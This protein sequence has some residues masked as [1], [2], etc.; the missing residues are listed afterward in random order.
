MPDARLDPAAG[1]FPNIG[2]P[3]L[4]A[5]RLAGITR[6]EDCAAWTRRDLAA[7]HGVGPKAIRLIEEALAARGLG[8]RTP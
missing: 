3:A 5:L 6:L 2:Q 8:Y 1:G 4:Q 7:L